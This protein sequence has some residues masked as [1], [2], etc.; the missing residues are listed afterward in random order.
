MEQFDQYIREVEDFFQ[1]RELK[2][3]QLVVN[4]YVIITDLPL[5]VSSHLSIVKAHT[6]RCNNLPYLR[7]LMWVKRI[8]ENEESMV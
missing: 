4:K 8:L 7:R 3:T 6:K 5:F 1:G 2:K